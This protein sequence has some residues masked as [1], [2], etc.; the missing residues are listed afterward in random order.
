ML[1]RFSTDGDRKEIKEKKNRDED[2]MITRG[3]GKKE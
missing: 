2:S 3:K 1:R